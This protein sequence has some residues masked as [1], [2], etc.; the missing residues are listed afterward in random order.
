MRLGPQASRCAHCFALNEHRASG[1]KPLSRSSLPYSGLSPCS[2]CDPTCFPRVPQTLC[3]PSDC[4]FVR[5]PAQGLWLP[6]PLHG[7][8]QHEPT[9]EAEA[10]GQI[11]ERPGHPPP[12]RTTQRLLRLRLS[13]EDPR[14]RLGTSTVRSDEKLKSL[15]P[16]IILLYNLQSEKIDVDFTFFSVFCFF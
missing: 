6:G 11:L 1:Q 12:L 13:A 9:G 3:R 4:P 8:V 10:P 14:N 7:R 2:V 16:Q 15:D 5:P